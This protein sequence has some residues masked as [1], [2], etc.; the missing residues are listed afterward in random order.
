M[1]SLRVILTAI[2]LGWTCPVSAS[3]VGNP[4]KLSQDETRHFFTT[5]Y[6]GSFVFD[7]DL[8]KNNA[9]VDELQ[10]SYIRLSYVP[11]THIMEVYG[12]LGTMRFKYNQDN[13]TYDTDYGFAYGFGTR[14][15]LWQNENGTAV[16]LDAKYRR[17]KP[18]LDEPAVFTREE[19]KY[20]DWQVALG[21]SQKLKEHLT[22]YAGVRYNDVSITDVP[23]IP[24]QNSD[25]VI[26]LFTGLDIEA[27]DNLVFN[28]E[29][30]FI[31]E[32]AINGGVTWRF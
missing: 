12:L 21:V 1:K 13:P 23:G 3:P 31:N 27:T 9:E 32:S 22:P 15:Q 8:D 26:G 28:L 29:G 18:D 30:G 4:A 14:T 6:E 10:D 17:S 5:G 7:R 11:D 2:F 19:V 16:G 25:D 24:D 20:Q